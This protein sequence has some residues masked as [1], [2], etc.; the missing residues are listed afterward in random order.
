MYYLCI[1]CNDVHYVFLKSTFDLLHMVKVLRV[2]MAQYLRTLILSCQ[3]HSVQ[4]DE[5]AVHR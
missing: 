3:S 2:H 5:V 4:V 1:L